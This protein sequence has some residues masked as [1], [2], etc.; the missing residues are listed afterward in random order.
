MG[1]PSLDAVSRGFRFTPN[2][3]SEEIK[4]A[5]PSQQANKS[6]SVST[7]NCQTPTTSGRGYA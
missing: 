6:T 5:S 7:Q 1:N 4:Q 2:P 3:K